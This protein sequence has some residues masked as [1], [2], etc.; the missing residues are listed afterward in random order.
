M[1]VSEE[2]KDREN[3]KQEETSSAAEPAV[4]DLEAEAAEPEKIGRASCRE[5]V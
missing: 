3:L 1:T 4:P 5:R 2:M